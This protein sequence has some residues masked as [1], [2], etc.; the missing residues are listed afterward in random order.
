MINSQ[1][2]PGQLTSR[3]LNVAPPKVHEASNILM[4]AGQH[5]PPDSLLSGAGAVF[6]IM[7]RTFGVSPQKVL[8]VSERA[9]RDIKSRDL[10]AIEDYLRNEVM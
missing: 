1:I 3:I 9:S 8:E 6:L 7:C 2:T 5:L 4:N 10:E